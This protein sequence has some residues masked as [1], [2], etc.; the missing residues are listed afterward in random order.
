MLQNNKLI[1]EAPEADIIAINNLD[2][3]SISSEQVADDNNYTPP[4]S[5]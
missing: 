3:L 2:V 1:Y 5:F 4:H